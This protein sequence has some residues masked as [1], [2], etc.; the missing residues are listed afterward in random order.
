M[1]TAGDILNDKK[2]DMITVRPEQTIREALESMQVNRI[3]AILVKRADKIVGIWTERDL[4]RGIL[5]RGFDIDTARVEDHM[6]TRLY[7]TPDDTPLL[8]LQEMF[9]GLFIRHILITQR[10]KTIGLLSIGDVMR[11]SLLEKD[12][13]IRDLTAMAGWEYYENWGWDRKLKPP[14]K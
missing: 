4:A 3:G 8:K 10:R 1:K 5:K 9:L 7:T 12:T 11:A 2:R 6:T 14:K 13:Q